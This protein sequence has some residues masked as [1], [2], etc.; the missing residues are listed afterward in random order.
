MRH[1]VIKSS[2]DVVLSGK[3]AEG[4]II[5]T[6]TETNVIKTDF[7]PRPMNTD[8]VQRPGEGMGGE[9]RRTQRGREQQWPTQDR[10]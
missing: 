4:L 7:L 8:N 3:K 1:T 10:V 6:C 5:P 2:R 9:G